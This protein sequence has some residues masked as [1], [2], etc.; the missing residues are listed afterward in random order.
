[1]AHRSSCSLI[2]NHTFRNYG[3]Y[4]VNVGVMNDVSDT[5]TSLMVQIPGHLPVPKHSTGEITARVLI[6]ILVVC[7]LLIFV[8]VIALR[9]WVYSRREKTEKADFDFRDEDATSL[10]S[11]D[12]YGKH[13]CFP[14]SG[15]WG[16]CTKQEY[17]PL[18]I[19]A[20]DY[21]MYTL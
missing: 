18:R 14:R 5:N 7:I 15:I 17:V 11:V 3:K 6:P 2:V 8:A 10:S 20:A 16:S 21:K 9:K 1:M 12:L 19:Q 4:C 13:S